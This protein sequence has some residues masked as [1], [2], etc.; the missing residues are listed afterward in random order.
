MSAVCGGITLYGQFLQQLGFCNPQTDVL[1][2]FGG[3]E[4]R[5][6]E[7]GVQAPPAGVGTINFGVDPTAVSIALGNTTLRAD[8]HSVSILVIDDATGAPL[9]L[10][11]GFKTT[12]TMGPTGLIET[13]SV[14]WNGACPVHMR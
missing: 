10:D 8:E 14:P 12:R 11:Y 4:F 9:S 6:H 13:V 7:G 1:T 3:A 2:V 5:P